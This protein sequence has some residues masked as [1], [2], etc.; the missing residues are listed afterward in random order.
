MQAARTLRKDED[1]LIDR[2]LAAIDAGQLVLVMDD[3]R[4]ILEKVALD[5]NAQALDQLGLSDD[6][7]AML[8]Q[9]NAGAIDYA[10]D[11][12]AELIG[13]R[14]DAD[15]ELVD[16]PRAEYAI[17]DSTRDMLRADVTQALED[18]WSNDQLATAI[19][20]NYAFSD[21]R[22]ETI[23]RTETAFADVAGN[24]G[25]WKA[26][27]QVESKQWIVG[28]ECCDDC[29]E[30]DGVIVDLDDDFPGD[31]GDG[32]PLHPNCRCDVLPI[33]TEESE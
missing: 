4:P 26:S 18:G 25:G 24:L 14:Y 28:A 3:I 22:A 32:P 16:N 11:R 21:E 30:L 7:E 23:A 17:D 12:A 27:G 2:L 33:L 13:K 8:R 15:G 5:G 10:K 31:G 20:D 29:Q 1:D 9:A 6:I 19:G